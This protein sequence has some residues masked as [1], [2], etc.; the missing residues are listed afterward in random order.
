[1][2]VMYLKECWYLP[3]LWLD[4]VTGLYVVPWGLWGETSIAIACTESKQREEEAVRLFELTSGMEFNEVDASL[5]KTVNRIKYW[6]E[7][8][9]IANHRVKL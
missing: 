4:S 5:A 2:Y 8:A 9:V 7:K 3:W 1:M 6:L